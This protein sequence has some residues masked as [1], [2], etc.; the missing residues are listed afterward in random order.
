MNKL[1]LFISSRVNSRSNAD[2][3]DKSFSL[4]ELR[5]FLKENLEEAALFQEKIWD[6]VINE[7][8]FDSPIARDAFDNCIG[9]MRECNVI[10]I[11]YTGEAGWGTVDESNGICHEEF[12][13]AVQEFSKMTFMLD[14]RNYFINPERDARLIDKN[15]NF[16]IDVTRNFGHME[17][18]PESIRTTSELF[19]FVLNQ[20]KKY[21]L[22]AIELSFS[23]QKRIVSASSVFG[24]TLDWS[25]LNYPEREDELKDMLSKVF[26]SIPDFEKVIKAFHAIPDHMSIADARNRIGRPFVYEHKLLE[27][28]HE[29]SGVIHFIGVYG[30]VTETQ[31]KTLVGYPDITVIKGTFGFYLWEK[32]VHIQIFFLRNCI[33]PQTVRTRLSEVINWLNSSREKS[34]ILKRSEAR[35]SILRTISNTRRIE[36]I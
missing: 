13:V 3:L 19:Q 7:T 15:T 20:S 11:L 36:G 33:N 2:L 1:K 8:D 26:P 24:E 25:K 28:R 6:V 10:I 14:L 18:P 30:N 5:T 16:D 21:L 22:K 35:Y 9:K 32:N 4:R 29:I 12:I 31:A 17:S 23:T 27:D 34:K